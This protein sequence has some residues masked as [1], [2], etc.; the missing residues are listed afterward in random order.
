MRTNTVW[1]AV[2]VAATMTFASAATAQNRG[3]DDAAA[4]ERFKERDT[5]GDGKLSLE[6]A[7]AGL[8]GQRLEFTRRSFGAMDVNKDNYVTLGE[9][10]A[11]YKKLREAFEKAEAQFVAA[12]VNADERLTIAELTTGKNAEETKQLTELFDQVDR[13]KD[14]F[15]SKQEW[16]IGVFVRMAQEAEAAAEKEKKAS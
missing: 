15:L 16:R 7:T 2:A 14:G 12:D 4:E 3:F 6:E 1:A 11:Y 10:K 5:N 8:D 9:Q 13:D